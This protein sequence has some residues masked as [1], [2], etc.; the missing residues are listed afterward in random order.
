MDNPNKHVKTHLLKF[1][2]LACAAL[3]AI[4]QLAAGADA[5]TPPKVIQTVDVRF[6]TELEFT[7]T[8]SGEADVTIKVDAGGQLADLLVTG[9]THKAFAREAAATI[10]EWKFQPAL[11]GG[12][13]VEGR[14]RINIKFTSNARVV[15]LMPVETPA[16]LFRRAGIPENV[17]L[18]CRADELDKPLEVLHP[19][20]PAHP[21]RDSGPS[22]G[23]TVV[24]F[25][26]DET[27][28]ARL[29]IVV[30]TTHPSFSEATL[31]AIGNWQF[32]VPTRGGN[33][34]IVRMQQTFVFSGGT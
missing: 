20:T 26:V 15:T 16:A 9:Y 7:A 1:A 10:R 32:A 8:S 28:H 3:I 6:P 5:T 2:P 13:P 27:G 17:D 21:G 29:P 14:V 12:T 23:H 33:P 19:E 18:V 4:P 30:E 22:E 11:A 34:V 31:R 25:F 24:D